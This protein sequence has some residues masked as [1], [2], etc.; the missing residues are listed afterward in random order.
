MYTEYFVSK[1]PDH[2]KLE[3][4]KSFDQIALEDQTNPVSD[5]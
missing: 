2:G 4:S 3:Q 1:K 5:H